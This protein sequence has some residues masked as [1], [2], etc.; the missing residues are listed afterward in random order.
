MHIRYLFHIMRK[1]VAAVEA[2][3]V[4]CAVAGVGVLD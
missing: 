2:L 4:L 3:L 1:A